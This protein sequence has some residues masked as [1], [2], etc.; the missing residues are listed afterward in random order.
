[1]SLFYITSVYLT[2][3]YT[4]GLSAT[5]ALHT[6]FQRNRYSCPSTLTLAYNVFGA[7]QNN[8]LWRPGNL[9]TPKYSG[10]ILRHIS[11]MH[12][13]DVCDGVEFLLLRI[14]D[15]TLEVQDG[16]MWINLAGQSFQSRRQVHLFNGLDA[17]TGTARSR[18]LLPA[19]FRQL[20][21]TM[22]AANWII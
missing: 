14:F 3:G 21:A 5:Y 15:I 13:H 7:M 17:V 8:C 1:M 19:Y 22:G 4:A 16:N 20:R 18:N 6:S 11:C 9:R 12:M 10:I 2:Y